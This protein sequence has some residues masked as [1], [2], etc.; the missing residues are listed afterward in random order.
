VA[1][2]WER[3]LATGTVDPAMPIPETVEPF[4]D[5]AELADELIT[6]G[7]AYDP[8]LTTVFERFEVLFAE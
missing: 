2:F 5:S 8:E 6:L 7:I 3:F 1:G 4:G